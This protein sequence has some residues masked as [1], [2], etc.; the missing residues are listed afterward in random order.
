MSKH[1]IHLAITGTRAGATKKQL[2]V[3]ARL[4]NSVIQFKNPRGFRWLHGDC[5]GVD[6]EFHDLLVINGLR[7]EIEI[8]PCDILSQRAFKNAPVI[9]D[10]KPPL[11][12][13]QDIVNAAWMLFVVPKEN[14]EQLRSGTW[15]T[16]RRAKER[17]ISRRIIFPDGTQRLERSSILPALKEDAVNLIKMCFR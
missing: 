13:N 11:E 1:I 3:L 5:I 9:H 10:P 16:Y 14:T 7:N 12:R 8:Y 2:E 15:A 6:A 4:I 17:N